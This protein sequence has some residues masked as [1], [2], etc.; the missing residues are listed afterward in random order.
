MILRFAD[1]EGDPVAIDG[2]AIVGLSVGS[3]IGPRAATDTPDLRVTL[4]WC[5]GAAQP[6]MVAASFEG[7][8]AAWMAAR[9]QAPPLSEMPGVRGW[10]LHPALMTPTAQ[11]PKGETP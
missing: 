4:V 11:P 9:E 2:A 10:S 6:F 8:L 1:H 5:A 3:L 7:V